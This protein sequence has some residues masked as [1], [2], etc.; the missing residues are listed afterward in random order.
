MSAIADPN[1]VN[2]RLCRNRFY[3]G[4]VVCTSSTFAPYRY[5]HNIYHGTLTP[6][7][8]RLIPLHAPPRRPLGSRQRFRPSVDYP[9]PRRDKRQ[10]CKAESDDHYGEES[11]GEDAGDQ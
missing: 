8:F 11:I 10:E 6:P 4:V 5:L 9:I 3:K 2:D 1:Q 7:I